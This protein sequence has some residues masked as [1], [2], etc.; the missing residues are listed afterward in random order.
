VRAIAS[1]ID[2]NLSGD[3][4]P[5]AIIGGVAVATLTT[6]TFLPA[7]YVFWFRVKEP[8]LQ[9][10]SCRETVPLA[11]APSAVADNV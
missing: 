8:L 9:L 7:L 10:K 6:L 5:F 3:H 4:S 11:V 1:S 2:L